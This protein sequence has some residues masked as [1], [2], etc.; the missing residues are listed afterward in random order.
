MRDHVI[1]VPGDQGECLG[2]IPSV[3]AV[4]EWI[5]MNDGLIGTSASL[6]GTRPSVDRCGI[7][8]S[9]CC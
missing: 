1:L 7:M 8:V 3:Y 6:H 9:R 4:A 2:A 5:A